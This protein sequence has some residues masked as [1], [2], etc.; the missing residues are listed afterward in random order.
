MSGKW[1]YGSLVQ[2]TWSFAGDDKRDEVNFFF[3]QIFVN[4]NIKNG[5]YLTS[6]PIITADWTAESGEQWVVPLGGGFGKVSL[7]GKTPVDFQIQAFSYV[8]KPEYGPDWQLRL[9]IKPMISK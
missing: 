3:S 2:N 6:A 7:I 4:F 9:Q 1:V 5:W 8:A